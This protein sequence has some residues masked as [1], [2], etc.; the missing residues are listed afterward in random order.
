MHVPVISVIVPALNAEAYIGA[1]LASVRDQPVA[2]CEAIV[3][4]AGSSDATRAIAQAVAAADGRFRLVDGGRRLNA[5]EARNV[6]LQHAR[7]DYVATLDSDD[8]MLPNRLQSALGNFADHPGDV[9]TG[10]ALALLDSAGLPAPSPVDTGHGPTTPAQVRA[11]LPFYCP[12]L[13]SA[14]TYR[15]SA[16][17]EL[18]GFDE[19]HPTIDDYPLLW[20]LARKGDIHLLRKPVAA[21]RRHGDQLTVTSNS[22]SRW[23]TVLLRQR[24]ATA[25]LGRRPEL[26][27]VQA[28]SRN[29]AG[30]SRDSIAQA[31]VDT[32]EMADRSAGEPS[33]TAADRAWIRA[34]QSAREKVLQAHLQ[35]A[36][37][38]SA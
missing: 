35:A 34:A 32:A 8:I 5:P 15:R 33:S 25:I 3:V 16:L 18:N 26:D 22:R 21:Y 10:G 38:D 28:W 7:A 23:E 31:L 1:A 30:A 11:A 12:T 6:G 2:E 4:D 17:L 37:E 24:I 36:D 9:A 14:M 20:R 27:S 19:D 13:A 29:S